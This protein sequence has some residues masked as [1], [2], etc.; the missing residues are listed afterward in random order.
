[1]TS[2]SGNTKTQEQW[3]HEFV[4]ESDLAN[5]GGSWATVGEHL[6]KTWT[7]ESLVPPAWST[8]GAKLWA[9]GERPRWTVLAE[10]ASTGFSDEALLHRVAHLGDERITLVES[11]DLPIVDVTIDDAV[12]RAAIFLCSSPAVTTPLLG[13]TANVGEVRESVPPLELLVG[14]PQI[15]LA[16]ASLVRGPSDAPLI[17]SRGFLPWEAASD[18]MVRALVL[19]VCTYADR[20]QRRFKL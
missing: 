2:K 11:P 6:A 9:S 1:M 16:H 13:V 8:P 5:L 18:S 4:D 17:I 10:P 20:L 15:H 3:S 19:Q 14:A 7:T 12:I